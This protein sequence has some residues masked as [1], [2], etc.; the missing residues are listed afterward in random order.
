[1][2]KQTE[3]ALKMAIEWIE[4]WYGYSPSKDAVLKAC[5]KALKQPAQEPVGFVVTSKLGEHCGFKSTTVKKG[6]KIYTH[7]HQWQG[8][9]DD[10]IKSKSNWCQEN[11]V[12]TMQVRTE[13]EWADIW[14]HIGV[15]W[16]EQALKE[17]NHV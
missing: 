16:A 2:N 17:K 3:D 10:E 15:K 13:M 11:H 8:L 12:F 9:T 1:M 6:D 7:P 4:G 14:F 5:K